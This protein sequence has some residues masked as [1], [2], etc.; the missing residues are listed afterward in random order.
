MATPEWDKL[1]SA[2]NKARFNA[3]AP[4]SEFLV[5]ASV[6]TVGGEIF[7]GCNVENAS[8]GLTICAERTA[9]VKMVSEIAFPVLAAVCVVLKGGHMKGGSPCGACR[10]FIW[11]FCRGNEDV[12]VLMTDP[13]D[14]GRRY[15][16]IGQLLPEAFVL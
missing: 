13:D 9:L 12:P 1:L 2:A 15:S 10:Q 6:Q 7:S 4:Y 16:T 3:Y 11:E 14:T 8:Y 5:G